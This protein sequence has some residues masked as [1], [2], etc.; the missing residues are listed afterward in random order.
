[1]FA[2]TVPRGIVGNNALSFMPKSQRNQ[3]PSDAPIAITKSDFSM[4]ACLLW[5][6]IAE[7]VVIT[8]LYERKL[9]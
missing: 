5:A 2:T 8:A 3:A 6:D 1:M 4:V 7:E 9:I